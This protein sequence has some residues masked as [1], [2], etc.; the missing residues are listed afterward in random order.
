MTEKKQSLE[1]DFLNSDASLFFLASYTQLTDFTKRKIVLFVLRN[2]EITFRMGFSFKSGC[3]II[4]LAWVEFPSL[5]GFE[6]KVKLELII[7][8]IQDLQNFYFT[9]FFLLVSSPISNQLVLEEHVC[10][11]YFIPVSTFGSYWNSHLSA[12]GL[13]CGWDGQSSDA[14]RH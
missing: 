11:I 13:G 14:A 10:W 5:L 12:A 9:R 2:L 8:R 4:L 1:K 6:T 7:W 3:S